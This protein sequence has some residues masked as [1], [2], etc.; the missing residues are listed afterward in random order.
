MDPETLGEWAATAVLTALV[1]YVGWRLVRSARN[2]PPGPNGEVPYG[3]YGWLR[4]AIGFLCLQVIWAVP[5]ALE[6][7]DL[8][9]ESHHWAV[10]HTN[11]GL[12]VASAYLLSAAL[13]AWK[14]WVAYL[15]IKR[16]EPASA[17]MARWNFGAAPVIETVVGLSL[18]W[19]LL[20]GTLHW[21]RQPEFL[22]ELFFG[23]GVQWAFMAYFFLSRRV[24]N[25]YRLQAQGS[26]DI[27]QRLAELKQLKDQA[28]ISEEDYQRKKQS[29]LAQL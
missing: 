19:A 9:K 10:G 13:V 25:T 1:V 2:A 28:L 23:V 16:F 26:G 20:G 18:S 12:F 14:A 3:N 8:L 11:W 5:G 29:L 21:P 22:Q 27:K 7:H 17:R 15:L 4:V 24:K 6:L